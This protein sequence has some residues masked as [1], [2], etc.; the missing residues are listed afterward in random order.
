MSLGNDSFPQIYND[1]HTTRLH[2]HT[3]MNAA[4]IN[5]VIS[6]HMLHVSLFTMSPKRVN[7]CQ[8]S[9]QILHRDT[10]Y[11]QQGQRVVFESKTL[12][13]LHEGYF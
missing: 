3:D 4:L 11:H 1:K 13:R 9:Q 6:K 2:I 5:P 12:Q 7:T 10:F 8:V